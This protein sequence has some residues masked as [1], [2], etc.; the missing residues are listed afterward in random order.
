MFA[1]EIEN[2]CTIQSMNT[3]TLL[4]NGSISRNSRSARSASASSKGR[5]CRHCSDRHKSRA[6]QN[7][8]SR[9]RTRNI[10]GPD[11][12]T[13]DAG[14]GAPCAQ[15]QP[16]GRKLEG[17]YSGAVDSPAESRSRA[18]VAPAVFEPGQPARQPAAVIGRLQSTETSGGTSAQHRRRAVVRRFKSR[19]EASATTSGSVAMFSRGPPC[20]APNRPWS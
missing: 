7:S 14:S 17:Y 18:S 3:R 12:Y 2:R 15:P 1:P 16:S 6:G 9:H 19:C 8:A 5:R 20:R 10:A 4:S 11:R 13:S